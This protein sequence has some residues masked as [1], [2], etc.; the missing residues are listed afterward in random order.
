VSFLPKRLSPLI[1]AGLLVQQ[2][3]PSPDHLTIVAAPSQKAAACPGCAAPSLRVHSRYERTLSD[4]PWQGRPASLRVLAR[5]FRCL[6][7]AC[8]RAT[9]TERLPDAAPPAA[10]RTTR[11]AGLQRHLGLALGGEA[12]ARLASHL[13]VPASPDTLLRMARRADP[14]RGPRPPVRVLGVDDWAWRRGHRYG[15][16]L[17]DLERNRVVDLLPDRR[18]ETLAAWLEANPGVEV[19]ARDRAGAFADGVRRGAPDAAQVA[20]RWH[21]LENCSRALL[22]AVRRRRADVRAATAAAVVLPAAP[23]RSPSG[24]HPPMTSAERRQ[25]QRWR[26]G[27]ELHGE[28][29]R[30]H[31]A[32]VSIKAIVRRLGVGRNTVRRWLRGAA[33]EPYRPRRSTLGLHLGALERRWAE[34]CHNGAQLWRELRDGAGFRGGL[35]VV[36]E[37]AARRRLASRPGRMESGFGAPASRRVARMLTADPE[38]LDGAGRRY[39]DHLLSISPPLARARELALRFADVVRARRDGELDG[40]LAEADGSELRSF[41]AGLRQDEAAVRAALALPWSSGQTEGQITRLK[42][43]K[44]TMYGRAG[45]GL[46]RARV[47]HAA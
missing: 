46:L 44:R 28:V 43:I 38:T 32:G 18:A 25:W 21:L 29:V 14:A 34:G 27:A 16:I 13:S 9:F 19:V 5:R 10:R 3:L 17:V 2:I 26:R 22:D 35:R 12:G 36:T 1:P 47:L 39:L 15:T 31:R 8:P 11:L 45:F 30:L 33:P 40:W 20:D 24:G 6:N 41:A 42:L 23:E 7:P 4:L 37:W